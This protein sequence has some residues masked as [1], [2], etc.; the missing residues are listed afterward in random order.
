MLAM[1]L[2]GMCPMC[3]GMGLG[4]ILVWIVLIAAVVAVVWLLLRRSRH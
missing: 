3:A 1:L 2:Q 4:M